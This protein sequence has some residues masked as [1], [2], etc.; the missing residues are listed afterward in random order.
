MR[1][2]FLAVQK[3]NPHQG[4]ASLGMRAFGFEL[5][6]KKFADVRV[7]IAGEG[8]PGDVNLRF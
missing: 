8:A 6:P 5:T 1:G 7:A 3:S 2:S 4:D